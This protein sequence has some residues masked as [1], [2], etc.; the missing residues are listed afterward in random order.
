MNFNNYL[1][2]G[3]VCLLKGA[4]KR[5]MITGYSKNNRKIRAKY[6][7]VGCEYPT[8][9]TREKEKLYFLHSKIDKIFF[10]GYNDF[11]QKQLIKSFN[12]EKPLSKENSISNVIVNRK[13]DD[14]VLFPSNDEINKDKKVD[15]NSNISKEV[16]TVEKVEIMDPKRQEIFNSI[17]TQ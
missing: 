2:I 13:E 4:K 12:N 8:G 16:K 14:S 5:V 9:V 7:Y 15:E 6:D 17:P 1:P 10:I 3:T 11:E